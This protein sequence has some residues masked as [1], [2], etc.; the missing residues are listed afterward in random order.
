MNPLTQLRR[1]NQDNQ[2]DENATEP[3]TPET[4]RNDPPPPV[5]EPDSPLES[6]LP[7]PEFADA[8]TKLSSQ[9]LAGYLSALKSICETPR[10]KPE[11]TE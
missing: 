8:I 6:T 4:L 9:E 2:I 5:A 10:P 1:E 7:S 11:S 3:G